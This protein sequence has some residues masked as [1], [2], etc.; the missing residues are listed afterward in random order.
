VNA[1]GAPV[2]EFAA[3]TSS[4]RRRG[5]LSRPWIGYI[6][7]AFLVFLAVL[8][9][10]GPQIAPY[11]PEAQ[12]LGAA[13][14]PPFWAHGG[15]TQH[16]LGTDDLGR[17]L[18]SRIIVGARL[19]LLIALLGA[20]FEAIIGVSAGLIAG[21][22]GGWTDRVVMRVT[23]IQMAFPSVLMYLLIVLLIGSSPVIMALAL[24]VNGWMVFARVTRMTVM[25]LRREGFVEAAVASGVRPRK[26][27]TSHI[28][29][30]LR[31]TVLAVFLFEMPRFVLA[32]STLSFVGLGVHPPDVSW[33]LI[34]GSS[35][36]LLASAPYLTVLPGIMIVLSAV[37]LNLFARYLD[38]VLDPQRRRR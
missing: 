9:V 12:D 25:R 23:D 28:I 6:S 29:P 31:G 18:L 20:T 38:P 3:A 34:I 30:H 8:V 37:S 16:W 32:E 5:L 7:G 10:F 26:V 1:V 14:L 21:F 4:S 17:D 13:M 35:R 15:T 24:A 2:E 33:G 27:V 22:H 36:S 19:T 11:D